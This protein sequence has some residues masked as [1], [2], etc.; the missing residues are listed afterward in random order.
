MCKQG[1][2]HLYMRNET[3]GAPKGFIFMVIL[4]GHNRV[5]E[6]PLPKDEYVMWILVIK[7]RVKICVG[8]LLICRS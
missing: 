7:L 3:K 5:K 1:F 8:A 6:Q 2:V 4:N